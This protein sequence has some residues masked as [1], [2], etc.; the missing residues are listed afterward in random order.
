MKWK[1]SSPP[2]LLRLGQKEFGLE[3]WNYGQKR[4]LDEADSRSSDVEA[5]ERACRSSD[6]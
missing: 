5:S 4:S 2:S 3:K 1:K 6:V